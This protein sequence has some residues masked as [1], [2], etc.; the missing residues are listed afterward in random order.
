MSRRM[1]GKTVLVTGAGGGIG[2]ATPTVWSAKALRSPSSIVDAGRAEQAASRF[3]EITE[4]KHVGLAP[5]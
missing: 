4:P 1:E 2:L 5:T 3:T